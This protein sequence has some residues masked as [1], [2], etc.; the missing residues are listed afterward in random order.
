MRTDPSPLSQQPV[1][2]SPECIGQLVERLRPYDLSKGEIVMILNL[3]PASMAA[4]NTIIE[5]RS[6]RFSEDQ[7]EEMV[8]IVAEVLG[9][10][11]AEE[12]ENQEPVEEGDETMDDAAA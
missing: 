8:N 4:L 11:E 9:R 7:Q 10:F 1:T 3:R 6:D 5:D 12:T 2:Y